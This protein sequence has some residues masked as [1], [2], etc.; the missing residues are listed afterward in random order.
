[1]SLSSCPSQAT[2]ED[3]SDDDELDDEAMMKLDGNIAAL[4]LEQKKKMQAKKDEK[5]KLKKEKT[6]VRDFKIKVYFCLIC[7]DREMS[8]MSG[9]CDVSNAPTSAGFRAHTN[10]S[11]TQATSSAISNTASCSSGAGPPYVHGAL[12]LVLC[13]VPGAGP[14][15]GVPGQAGQQ[16][17]GAGHGGAP[18]QRHR[19]RHEL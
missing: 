11:V 9:R 16:P 5:D 19:E 6:L 7:L 15:G 12:T 10:N 3:G 18:A 17:P 14:G 1:M 13:C 4:F 8:C 2:E